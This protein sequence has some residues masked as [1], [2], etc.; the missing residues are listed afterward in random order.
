MRPRCEG[1]GPRYPVAVAHCGRVHTFFI[2]CFFVEGEFE[3]EPTFDA[4]VGQSSE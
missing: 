1:I 3:W 2:F 4:M